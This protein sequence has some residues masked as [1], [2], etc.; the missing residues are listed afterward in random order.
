M[1]P[2][3]SFQHLINLE[4]QTIVL[5]HTHWI[6]LTQIMAFFHERE[7]DVSEKRPPK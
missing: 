2:H 7:Y 1:L 6:A 4:R 5:L 3:A